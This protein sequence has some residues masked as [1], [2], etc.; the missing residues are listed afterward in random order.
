MIEKR[1]LVEKALAEI[2]LAGS[3]FDLPPAE[4]NDVLTQLEGYMGMLQAQ[5]VN[6]NYQFATRPFE[7][8]ANPEE[9]TLADDSGIALMHAEAIYTNL[10]IRICPMF[11]KTPSI[12][13]KVAAKNAHNAMLTSI[14]TVAKLQ[15][16]CTYPMGA[17]N[18]WWRR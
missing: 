11:G 4:Q 5:G 10:A 9:S 15:Y 14:V 3:V 16:P 2:G 8:A 13:L 1:Y 7:E 6:V 18:R 17:G 12:E